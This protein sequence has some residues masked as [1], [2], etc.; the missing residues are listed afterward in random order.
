MTKKGLHDDHR[1]RMRGKMIEAGA[2]MPDHEILEILLFK[3][4]P[5]KD[6]NPVAHMLIR[7]FGSLEN[8]LSADYRDLEKIP[9]VTKNAALHL[10]AIKLCIDRLN[11]KKSGPVVT[12]EKIDDAEALARSR[13]QGLPR[14]QCLIVLLSASNKVLHTKILAAGGYGGVSFEIRPIVDEA[15]RVNAAKIL[16]A[17][18]HPSG[19]YHPSEADRAATATLADALNKMSIAMVDHIIV[20]ENGSFSFMFGERRGRLDET[21]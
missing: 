14:E 15:V 21:T 12:I 7:E 18:N 16:L 2:S 10:N 17:H 9:N 3:D 1:K 8:V 5:R 4:T 19:N 11:L 13:L 6:T 20:T